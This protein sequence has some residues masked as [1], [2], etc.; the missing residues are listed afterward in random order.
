MSHPRISSGIYRWEFEKGR[1]A[2]TVNPQG[3]A[4]FDDPDLVVQAVLNGVGIGMAMEQP[5]AKIIAT[6][7]AVGISLLLLPP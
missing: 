3:P 2:L 6:I 1:T 4:T 5:L 7:R